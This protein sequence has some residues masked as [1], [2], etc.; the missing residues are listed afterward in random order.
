MTLSTL[1]FA[2]ATIGL[3]LTYIFGKWVKKPDH[4]W[5]SFLKNFVGVWFIFSGFVK[6][7][8]PMGTAF[9]MEQYFAAFQQTFEATKASFLVPLFSSLSHYTVSFSIFMILLEILLGVALI[10]GYAPK[11]T[12]W[13]LLILLIFFTKLTGFTYLTGYVPSNSNFFDFSAWGDYEPLQMRVSDCGCFGDFLKLDPKVSFFKDLFLLIPGVLFVIWAKAK[14]QLWTV[15]V[16]RG[17]MVISLL[18]SLLFCSYN[19][20]MNEPIWDFRPFRNGADI[21]TTRKMELDAAQAVQIEKAQVK[22]KKSG[23]ILSV[24]YATYMKEFKKYPKE[25]W[26][27]KFVYGESTVTKTKV[28]EFQ[29]LDEHGTDVTLDI[30]NNEGYSLMV[31][32]YKIHGNTITVDKVQTDSIFIDSLVIQNKDT[33][34]LKIFAGTNQ[35]TNKVDQ[36]EPTTADFDIF[37]QQINPLVNVLTKEG[38]KTFAVTG[39]LGSSH[40]NDFAQKINA[41]YPIYQADDILLKTIMRS[42]PGLILWKNGKIIQKWHYKQLPSLEELRALMK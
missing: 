10:I 1:I 34:R 16:R 30:L 9:K 4:W 41:A 24:P 36:F 42:N 17:I 8:D 35:V 21:A 27:T 23:E 12:A 26:D 22:N 3:L 7:V 11:L 33:V 32:A 31:N 40:M 29:I 37:D 39:G 19:T 6:A 20:F 15:G 28:S 18:V 38:I 25:D 13:I 14:H 5:L 2:F